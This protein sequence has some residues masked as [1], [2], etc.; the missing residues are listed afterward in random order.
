MD[1]KEWLKFIRNIGNIPI[2][3]HSTWWRLFKVTDGGFEVRND[4][5]ELTPADMKRLEYLKDILSR[6]GYRFVNWINEKM[7]TKL[8]FT[9]DVGDIWKREKGREWYRTSKSN[10]F[11]MVSVHRLQ[12]FGDHPIRDHLRLVCY[13]RSYEK[14]HCVEILYFCYLLL[15]NLEGGKERK[16]MHPTSANA[17]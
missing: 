16:S 4:T 17:K 8:I 12:Y 5:G 11:K 3:Q 6:R 10:V 2:A 14:W 13:K 9:V 1:A 15:C 7:N